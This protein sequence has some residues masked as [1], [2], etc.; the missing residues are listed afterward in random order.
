MEWNC[1]ECNREIISKEK[2]EFCLD[3][4]WGEIVKKTEINPENIRIFMEKYWLTAFCFKKESFSDILWIDSEDMKTLSSCK[5]IGL[6]TCY[7]PRTKRNIGKMGWLKDEF[8]SEYTAFL[9]KLFSFAKGEKIKRI[10]ANWKTEKNSN[11]ET[12][13]KVDSIIMEKKSNEEL[14]KEE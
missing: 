5:K 3:C 9:E 4:W 14:E 11:D 2:K 12:L 1:V 10:R 8:L 13:F 7:Y 6:E